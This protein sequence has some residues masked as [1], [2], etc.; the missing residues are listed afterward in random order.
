MKE[1]AKS[2]RGAVILWPALLVAVIASIGMFR[3]IPVLEIAPPGL[4][5]PVTQGDR[6]VHQYVHSMYRASVREI[7]TIENDCIELIHV[8]TP[9][10]AVLE[11]FGIEK[12]GQHNAQ[13]TFTGFTIPAASVGNHVIIVHDREIPLGTHPENLGSIRVRVVKL[14]YWRYL[15]HC[16]RG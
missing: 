13:G 2:G 4:F 10:D 5:V 12:R 14:L 11:Y 9:S 3:D 1:R 15:A 8:M 7:F 6:L 16:L